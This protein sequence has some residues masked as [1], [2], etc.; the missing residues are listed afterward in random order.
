ME[1][2]AAKE[3]ELVETKPEQITFIS[4]T[5]TRLQTT[6]SVALCWLDV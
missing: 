3:Q 5:Q 4:W 6:D 1:H 2:L